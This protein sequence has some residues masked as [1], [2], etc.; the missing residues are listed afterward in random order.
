MSIQLPT[1]DNALAKRL[2]TVLPY[3]DDDAECL[4]VDLAHGRMCRWASAD[5]TLAAAVH[6]DRFWAILCDARRRRKQP[7]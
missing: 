1:T 6:D 2:A 5:R 7:A 3:G 4:I